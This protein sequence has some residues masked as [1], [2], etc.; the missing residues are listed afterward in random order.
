MG[1]SVRRRSR[2]TLARAV[3]AHVV[4]KRLDPEAHRG[5]ELDRLAVDRRP[6]PRLRRA[7]FELGA[8]ALIPGDPAEAV[9]DVEVELAL[10]E[11]LALPEREQVECVVVVR[12]QHEPRSDVI[13]VDREA[14]AATSVLHGQRQCTKPSERIA[15]AAVVLAPVHE[16]GVDPERD[17]VQEEPVA[18]ARD[19]DPP[20]DPVVESCERGDRVVPVEP[21]VAGEMVP[22]PE[23][24]ADE[25]HVLLDRDRC[26]GGERAVAAG[27]SEH[28]GTRVPRQLR[29]VV[30]VLERAH[31]DAT[32]ARRLAELL[33]GRRV[34][35]GVWVDDQDLSHR[36][37]SCR[38]ER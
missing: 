20:F 37:G 35:A 5:I 2:V 38:P 33:G 4:R 26:D 16:A 3:R 32:A 34:R 7:D 22:R 6:Q 31:V 21:E 30:P 17:V 1:S 25:R 24:D 13:P 23:R 28:V 10:V 15:A 8:R 11:A 18:C 9:R 27:H 12:D 19:V 14:L 36:V 29:Q